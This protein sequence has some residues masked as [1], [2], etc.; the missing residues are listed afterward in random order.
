LH[1]IYL[2]IP[3]IDGSF[4]TADGYALTAKIAG[5]HIDLFDQP[6]LAEEFG[7]VLGRLHIALVK[8]EPQIENLRG[9]NFLDN[10]HNYVLPG[11]GDIAC[12]DLCDDVGAKFLIWPICWQA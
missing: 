9:S 12:T 8:I 4:V 11:L 2:H 6:H 7:R 3:A 1:N 5:T 10:W